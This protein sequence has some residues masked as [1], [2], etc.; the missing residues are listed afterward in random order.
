MSNPGESS[1]AMHDGESEK[2]AEVPYRTVENEES[3]KSDGENISNMIVGYAP[4]LREKRTSGDLERS[5][6][7]HGTIDIDPAP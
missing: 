4:A 5:D 1:A 6:P 7:S 2:E 3:E